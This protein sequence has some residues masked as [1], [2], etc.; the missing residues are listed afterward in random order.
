MKR[1]VK[2]NFMLTFTDLTKEVEKLCK[3]HGYDQF[4]LAAGSP[5]D[6]E[7]TEWE[8]TSNVLSEGLVQSLEKVATDMQTELDEHFK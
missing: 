3:K 7:R 5:I 6:G 2:S 1:G 4:F 8:L